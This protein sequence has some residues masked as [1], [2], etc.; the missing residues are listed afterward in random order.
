MIQ[1]QQ[2]KQHTEDKIFRYLEGN[3]TDEEQAW[4]Q[5]WLAENQENQRQFDE[6]KVQYHWFKKG[7]QPG[8]FNKEESWNRIK[9]GYY[10]AGYLSEMMN[11][12][13]QTRKTLMQ[14]LIP[15]AAA[16]FVAFM[17]GFYISSRL[18][19]NQVLP[20][21]FVFSEV[22][23]P[24]GSR[25]Q[26]TLPDGTKI[27]LNAGSRLRYPVN[28]MKKSREVKLEGEAYFDVTKM[29]D[30]IFIVKTSDVNIKVYG[31]LFNVKSYPEEN[32]I[33]TTLVEGSLAVEPIRDRK[34]RNP[35]FLKPNQSLNFY[36]P[37]SRVSVREETHKSVNKNEA[38]P[39]TIPSKIVVIPK[40]DPVPITS[41]KDNKWVI[42]S[43]ELNDLAIKLE[44]RYNVKITFQEES[45]KK[46]KFSGTLKEETFEQVL[47]II[48]ISAPILFTVIDNNVL[49]RED[50]SFRKKYD[51]MI[52]NP[53]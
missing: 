22:F 2:N 46:Y 18:N 48:Q 30:K 4:M 35:I 53:D 49:F 7:R 33:Q 20:D 45:L 1:E 14:I 38:A 15:A 23:V 52:K 31:T 50:P 44:R 39:Q 17:L 3:A 16:V 32:M 25:S 47:K 43:E 27:W 40:V 10:K 41:W 19:S 6:L 42:V 26:I 28:F 51:S 37:L 8:D 9:T 36:K 29:Q 11:R 12:K 5:H 34:G 24:L 21:K 13:Q